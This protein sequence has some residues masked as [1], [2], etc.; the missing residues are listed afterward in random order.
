MNA[1]TET[2]VDELTGNDNVRWWHW[3]RGLKNNIALCGEETIRGAAGRAEMSKCRECP[4]CKRIKAAMGR[5][6]V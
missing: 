1:E 5:S 4:D 3:V 6:R 2:S